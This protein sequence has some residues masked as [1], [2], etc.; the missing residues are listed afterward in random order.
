MASSFGTYCEVMIPETSLLAP[1]TLRVVRRLMQGTFEKIHLH[2]LSG[3]QS[4][5][6][7][8]LFAQNGFP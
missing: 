1:G 8:D 2:G 3:Q 5:K 7:I 4:L 6:L